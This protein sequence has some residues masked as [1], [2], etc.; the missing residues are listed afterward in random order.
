MC[1]AIIDKL[2]VEY[3][4]ELV[5]KGISYIKNSVNKPKSSL[6]KYI[7]KLESE[8]LVSILFEIEEN[9]RIHLFH[10]LYSQRCHA[11]KASILSDIEIAYVLLYNKPFDRSSQQ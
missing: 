4:F 3:G 1:K 9:E 2:V 5:K 7:N 10:L 6:E 8:M 11:V